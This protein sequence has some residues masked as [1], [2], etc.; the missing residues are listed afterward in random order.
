[1]ILE[2]TQHSDV[3][4]DV[5]DVHGESPR[6]VTALAWHHIAVAA[7]ERDPQLR[8]DALHEVTKWTSRAIRMTDG[9]SVL[10]NTAMAMSNLLSGRLDQMSSCLDNIKDKDMTVASMVL[11]ALF[12]YSKGQ[13]AD[14]L[15]QFSRTIR[16][17]PDCSATVRFGLGMCYYKLERP[18]MAVRCFERALQLD[19]Q[20][21]EPRVALAAIKLSTRDLTQVQPAMKLLQEAFKI[22]DNHPRVLTFFADHY[23]HRREFGKV[24]KLAERARSNTDVDRIYSEAEFQLGRAAHAQGLISKAH[25]HYE[26]A[27][28]KDRDNILAQFGLAQVFLQEHDPESA[29]RC[30]DIVLPSA[31]DDFST[32]HTMGIVL[33]RLGRED[34]KE[35]LQRAIDSESADP[36]T[37]LEFGQLMEKSDRGKSLSAYRAALKLMLERKTDTP[38]RVRGVQNNVA[39]I[40]HRLG[41]LAAAETAFK[42]IFD[43]ETIANV[44]SCVKL[45]VTMS[46]NLARLWEDMGKLSE[47]QELHEAILRHHVAYTDC[48][49]RLASIA[50]VQNR[51]DDAMKHLA[52]ALAVHEDLPDA[53]CM[54]G[55]IHVER[56]ELHAAQLKFTRVLEKVD[57]DDPY[58]L[59]SLGNIYYMARAEKK[60]RKERNIKHAAESYWKVLHS[61]SSNV[62]AA[63]GLGVILAAEGRLGA[64]GEI[65]TRVREGTGAM[66]DVVVNLAHIYMGKGEF[67]KAVTLYEAALRKHFKNSHPKI[68]LYLSRAYFEAKDFIKAEEYLKR[69]M[70]LAD[71][72]NDQGLRFNLGLILETKTR[73]FLERPETPL[74]DPARLALVDVEKA[75]ATFFEIVQQGEIVNNAAEETVPQDDGEGGGEDAAAAAA[76]RKQ[77]QARWAETVANSKAHVAVCD[78]LIKGAEAKLQK[79]Q[80]FLMDEETIRKQRDERLQERLRAKQEADERRREMERAGA[81]ELAAIAEQDMLVL[82]EE[83]VH[84]KP[85]SSGLAAGSGRRERDGE[86]RESGAGEPRRTK[87]KKEKRTKEIADELADLTPSVTKVIIIC[88]SF[89]CCFKK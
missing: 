26:S 9:N 77:L 34:G 40:Q 19:D 73:L 11:R 79:A 62:Y 50:R 37:L 35:L 59:L 14:A 3:A 80:A 68:M 13:Y 88:A 45:S 82:R 46:F 20:L 89:C 2:R 22:D 65:F 23:F 47:A 74:I 52:D 75:R 64:A 41:H 55:Q 83:M 24:A 25:T 51:L 36:D 1:L 5:T 16:A 78:E 18:D 76:A 27:V 69:C 85:L 10:I 8:E 15:S 44:D 81:A 4:G 70:E 39:V 71:S 31:P 17:K 67:L 28:A 66:G 72:K 49:L 38:E 60:E 84:W 12:H 54:M 30:L 6:V 58:A 21:I 7:G 43:E 42:Q 86:A 53:L 87:K 57:R 33:A 63:N 61:D 56:H 29:L 48:Y 32:L